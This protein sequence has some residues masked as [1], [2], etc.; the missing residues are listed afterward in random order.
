MTVS[1]VQRGKSLSRRRHA[2]LG[3]RP[4]PLSN[5]RRHQAVAPWRSPAQRADGLHSAS[6]TS[7]PVSGTPYEGV[8]RVS[9][10][11][12]FRC[13]LAASGTSG[14]ARNRFRSPRAL[15]TSP[16]WGRGRTGWIHW[17]PMAVHP[18]LCLPWRHGLL[19]EVVRRLL[20][21]T[22]P[23]RIGPANSGAHRAPPSNDWLL[24]NP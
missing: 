16:M 23:A 10:N 14:R 6:S 9:S 24:D 20:D 17:E 21:H 8:R 18:S 13:R 7:T 4:S 15:A 19:D 3:A 22:D 2:R 1:G 11:R 5:R 12:R